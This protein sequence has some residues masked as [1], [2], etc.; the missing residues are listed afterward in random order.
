[1]IRLDVCCVAAA[2]IHADSRLDALG[3][4][5]HDARQSAGAEQNQDLER[6]I[7]AIERKIPGGQSL[8][9]PG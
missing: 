4:I 1:L 9:F 6:K 2:Q 8:D 7:L 5:T 3:E